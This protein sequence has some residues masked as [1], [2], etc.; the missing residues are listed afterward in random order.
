MSP[1]I[2]LS[3]HSA[4]QE[5]QRV[6]AGAAR[7]AAARWSLDLREVYFDTDSSKQIR[8]ISDA[9]ALPGDARPFAIVAETAGG[10]GYERVAENVLEA[11]V[12]WVP[13]SEH[14]E[15]LGTL[16]GRF[17]GR[18]VCC[19]CVDNQRIGQLLAGMA[20]ALLPGAGGLLVVEGP[21]AAAASRQRRLGL[22]MGL[23]GSR[24]HIVK[25]LAANWTTAGAEAAAEGWLGPGARTAV[26]P[27]LVLSLNDEMAVGVL[28]VIERRQP[29]WGK[30]R[31]VGCDGLA[32]GGQ[33]LVRE[34]ILAATIVMP[35][36]AG[37]CVD[38]AARSRRGEGVPLVTTVPVK[39]YPPLETLGAKR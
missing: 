24:L 15:Y 10:G 23:K 20:R 35:A 12:G 1:W 14:P 39:A 18:L 19:A 29:D 4:K 21:Q 28:R 11:S 17:P 32:D 22:E 27:D 7:A 6:Q 38:L 2:L 30:I 9:I 16:R 36:T 5:Y 8:Q 25:T 34:G 37:I 33:R 13:A 26:R 31:A 3:L